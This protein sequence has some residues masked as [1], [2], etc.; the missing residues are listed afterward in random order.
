MERQ[1]LAVDPSIPVGPFEPLQ[2]VSA[3][4]MFDHLLEVTDVCL[5]PITLCQKHICV[6]QSFF[7]RD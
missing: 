6:V 7:R 5:F 3:L 1:Q 2:I 4:V